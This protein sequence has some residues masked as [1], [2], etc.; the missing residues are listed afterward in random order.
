MAYPTPKQIWLRTG[1][2]KHMTLAAFMTEG[3][4]GSSGYQRYLRAH[5]P[6]PAKPARPSGRPRIVIRTIS[7]AFRYLKYGVSAKAV[8]AQLSNIYLFGVYV[9]VHHKV[10]VVF[11]R[12]EAYVRSWEAD[13]GLKAYKPKIVQCFNWRTMRGS[14]SRSMHSWAIAVDVDPAAN[15]YNTSTH[16]I[17]GYVFECARLAGLACGYDWKSPKDPMHFE[18]R[19]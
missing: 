14:S 9:G 19:G 10:A 17:P 7:N 6:V 12:W 18:F 5:P 2:S 1:A 3:R 15:P 8:S 13:H 4:S 16:N 11:K